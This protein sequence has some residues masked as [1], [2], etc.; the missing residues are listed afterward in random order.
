[1]AAANGKLAI[2]AP[3]FWGT[4]ALAVL[5][6]ICSIVGLL[7]GAD[8]FYA[9]N[10]ETLPQILG[11]DLITLVLGVPLLLGCVKLTQKGSL[12]G[13]LLWTGLL[14]YVA[15]S[16]YF[17]VI[18]V[19]FNALFLVYI[20]IVALSLYGLLALLIQLQGIAIQDYLSPK[21]PTRPIALFLL[22]MAGMFTA[23]WI[24]LTLSKLFA[25]SSLSPVERHVIGLDGM[26]LLPLMFIG[27]WLLWRKRPWGYLLAGILLTKLATLGFTLLVNTGLLLI[28][29]QPVDWFQ[30]V[31]FVIIMVGA[32]MG[33][34]AFLD[35]IVIPPDPMPLEHSL[36]SSKPTKP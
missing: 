15:Y 31:L 33:L 25:E 23:L 20:A 32:L 12:K 13:V 16:Y 4:N 27:G 26:V 6:L 10:P 30:T 19:R 22:V 7:F 1:M 21:T 2:P 24:G 35:G 5:L 34:I 29:Q 11:Q 18:G 36:P 3:I 28:W 14:F 17:Y 9:A 8:G